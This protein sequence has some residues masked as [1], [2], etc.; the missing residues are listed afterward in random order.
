M[1]V[2]VTQ[3][4]GVCVYVCVS[5]YVTECV[6]VLVCEY[7]ALAPVSWEVSSLEPTTLVLQT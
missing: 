5:V 6:C 7:V 4:V 3:L 2:S 1:C